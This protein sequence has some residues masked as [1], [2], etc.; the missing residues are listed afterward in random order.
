MPPPVLKK[1][2]AEAD[3]LMRK[4]WR[5]VDGEL[6]FD[7]AGHSL[8][9]KRDFGDFEMFVDWKI[10]SKG[11]SGIYLRGSPQVQIWDPAQWPEGSGGL[12]NNQ[13]N[14]KNP[15]VKA[16]RPIGEWNTFYIKMAGEKV[17]VL[18]NGVPVVDDVVME[19]YWERDKPIYPLG[20]IELQAHST[21]L[22][23]KNIFIRPLS[24]SDNASVPVPEASSAKGPEEGF[25]SLFN[26]R[27]LSGWR[28]DTKGYIV[29][30]GVIAALPEGTGNLYTEKEYSDFDL[31]FE[32]KLIPGAN[33]GIG[34]RAPLTGDA[35]YIGMEIQVLDDSADQYKSLNPYQ[36]HGSIYGVVP[37]RRGFQKPVGEWNAEEIIARGRRITVIL[38]GTV[39]VDTDI[40]E[41][42]ASGTVDHREH[43]GLKNAAG[44]IGFL[45]HG[46]R[47]EF[48][49]L[50]IKELR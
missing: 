38:N 28:G 26:G 31:R 29:E 14:P 11:D 50:R 35:A 9:T 33:N 3:D 6:V 12:Y 41:A 40:D 23:F 2:Q 30:N 34:I 27:D 32:F 45:G 37:S 19:N 7:G 42:S 39:I 5:V 8:C 18:L 17:T 13:K 22:S 24:R 1:A 43:P 47:V 49:N 36:Y 16:D 4:H 46:S 48:R 20:Q 21:N 44:H 15:L 25:S 10:E